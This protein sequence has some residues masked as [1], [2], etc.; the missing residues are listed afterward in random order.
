MRDGQGRVS[1]ASVRVA[2]WTDQR[3]APTVVRHRP[4]KAVGQHGGKIRSRVECELAPEGPGA[5]SLLVLQNARTIA[6]NTELAAEVAV[7]WA[8]AR[9]APEEVV[10]RYDRSPPLVKDA[11]AGV[12]SGRPDAL[13]PKPFDALLKSRVDASPPVSQGAPRA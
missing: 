1:V 13:S 6:E 7:S 4:L 12:S 8:H 9:P 2:A 11:L 10:R 3:S 5:P